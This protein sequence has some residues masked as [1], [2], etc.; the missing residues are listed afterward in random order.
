MKRLLLGSV[1]LMSLTSFAS[2]VDLGKNVC[3]ELKSELTKF[4]NEHV[5]KSLEKDDEITESEALVLVLALE[6]IYE[7]SKNNCTSNSV[8]QF[9]KVKEVYNNFINN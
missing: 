3:H 4:K 9:E 8:T 7:D 5:M 1:F 2:S 6:S